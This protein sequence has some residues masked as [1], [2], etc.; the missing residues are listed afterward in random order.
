MS[1]PI[2]GIREVNV[3][4]DVADSCNCC[5]CIP[6]KHHH[7]VHKDKIPKTESVDTRVKKAI[8]CILL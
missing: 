7:K 5:C 2:A 4:L 8:Y 3:K 6:K 1:S